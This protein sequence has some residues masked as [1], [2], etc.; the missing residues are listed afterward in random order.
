MDK[1]LA[2]INSN[3]EDDVHTIKL[4]LKDGDI[5]ANDEGNEYPTQIASNIKTEE[6]ARGVIACAW[7]S[8]CWGLEI[9]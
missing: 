4:F 8:T 3:D 7:G 1:Y 9:L 5:W 6:E 2:E